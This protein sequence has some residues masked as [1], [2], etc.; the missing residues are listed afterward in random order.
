MFLLRNDAC[1]S[2]QVSAW[3]SQSKSS[4]SQ[5][6]ASTAGGMPST[7]ADSLML[8]KWRLHHVQARLA[9]VKLAEN[10]GLVSSSRAV[11]GLPP[12]SPTLSE[13]LHQTG[14]DQH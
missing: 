13:V 6:G 1:F 8:G 2:Q 4:A 10:L 12:G 7:C 3:S 11:L 9:H 5:I 14:D